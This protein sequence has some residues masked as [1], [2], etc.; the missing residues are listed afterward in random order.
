MVVPGC[1]KQAQARRHFFYEFHLF[2]R[3]HDDAIISENC[4]RIFFI[5]SFEARQKPPLGWP[6]FST[7][8]SRQKPSVRIQ[9]G[10]NVDPHRDVTAPAGSWPPQRQPLGTG[11]DG[12]DGEDGA[13]WTHRTAPRIHGRHGGWPNTH[14][15]PRR[16][17]LPMGAFLPGLRGRDLWILGAAGIFIRI[18]P[19]GSR[20]CGHQG[21][22]TGR[23]R[24][25]PMPFRCHCDRPR[26]G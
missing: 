11:E 23:R 13:G 7:H 4:T 2:N 1:P 14:P 25:P 20:L 15:D 24:S 10:T 16:V 8:P 9:R 5:L 22:E 19:T 3:T 12:G 17:P 6:A 18:P 26:L 21:G